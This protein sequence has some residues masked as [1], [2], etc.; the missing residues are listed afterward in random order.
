[1]RES[2]TRLCRPGWVPVA[3]L[4]GGKRVCAL[5]RIYLARRGWPASKE[6]VI[7][8]TQEK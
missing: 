4:A 5:C 8:Q 6:A 3:S 2:F 1:M 7:A